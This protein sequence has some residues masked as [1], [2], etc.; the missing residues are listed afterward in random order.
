MIRKKVS[1]EY[2][3]AYKAELSNFNI[4]VFISLGIIVLF[5][6]PLMSILIAKGSVEGILN[7]VI[8][9]LLLGVLLLFG[10]K[11]RKKFID[12]KNNL[13]VT[14]LSGVITQKTPIQKGFIYHFKAAETEKIEKIVIINYYGYDSWHL[15]LKDFPLE[16]D[17]W[18]GLKT[19]KILRIEIK[20]SNKVLDIIGKK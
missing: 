10:L 7:S 8:L 3:N 11:K 13:E 12:D 19:K 18:R 9:L 14:V 20:N 1:P 6:I 17:I 15:E 2:A 16:V 4:I 5:V